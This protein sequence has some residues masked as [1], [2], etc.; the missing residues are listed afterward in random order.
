MGVHEEEWE[1]NLHVIE[2]DDNAS[3][4]QQGVLVFSGD[5]IPWRVG[6]YEVSVSF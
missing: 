4:Q 5:K 3:D 6:R 1:G 2:T